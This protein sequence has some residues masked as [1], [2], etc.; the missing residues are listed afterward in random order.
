MQQA[1]GNHW[2]EYIKFKMTIW[3]THCDSNMVS[4]NL[5][6]KDA[7]PEIKLLSNRTERVENLIGNLGGL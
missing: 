7:G 5:H 2:L 4:H 3:S 1:T 6:V